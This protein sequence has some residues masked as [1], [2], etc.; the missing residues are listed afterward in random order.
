MAAK[1]KAKPAAIDQVISPPV[2]RINK[3]IS[4]GITKEILFASDVGAIPFFC[5]E[6]PE[7]KKV[8]TKP[9]P[10]AIINPESAGAGHCNG[11][12]AG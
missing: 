10:I 11:N 9:I 2:F 8:I 1:D 5:V 3:L 6:K 4:T 7:S 12:A